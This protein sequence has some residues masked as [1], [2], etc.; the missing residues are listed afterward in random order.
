MNVRAVTPADNACDPYY[1]LSQ[2]KLDRLVFKKYI[3][4]GVWGGMS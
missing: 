2:Y 1:S 4:E 3:R